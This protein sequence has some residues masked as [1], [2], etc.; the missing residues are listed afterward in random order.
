MFL[1]SPSA[2]FFVV[3]D[4][5]HFSLTIKKALRLYLYAITRFAKLQGMLLRFLFLKPFISCLLIPESC[6][7]HL[8]HKRN[9]DVSLS[10]RLI[11]PFVLALLSLLCNNL[12]LILYLIFSPSIFFVIA[13]SRFSVPKYPLSPYTSVSSPVNNSLFSKER[14]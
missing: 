9:D 8:K 4:F 7:E 1:P 10:L 6:F 13:Y 12:L 2:F 3:P 11:C 5:F 14:K